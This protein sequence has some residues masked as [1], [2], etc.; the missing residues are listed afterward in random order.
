MLRAQFLREKIQIA[1]LVLETPTVLSFIDR[2]FPSNKFDQELR[3]R[4]M[5][6]LYK[7]LRGK[8]S[9]SDLAF[10]DRMYITLGCTGSVAYLMSCSPDEFFLSISQTLR[11]DI[12]ITQ[13]RGVVH[14]TRFASFLA[15]QKSDLSYLERQETIYTGSYY[16]FE[17]GRDFDTTDP[18]VRVNIFDIG[19]VDPINCC[20]TAKWISH[21]ITTEDI[22]GYLYFYNEAIFLIIS[23]NDSTYP[24]N[25]F[26]FM[27]PMKPLRFLYGIAI[28]STDLGHISLPVSYKT[29]F[30]KIDESENRKPFVV[31]KDEKIFKRI[32]DVV[33]NDIPNDSGRYKL[34]ADPVVERI[35]GL[36]GD[37]EFKDLLRES[38]K[39]R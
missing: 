37:P 8:T 7:W 38:P 1:Q 31:T 22:P 35:L 24:P 10:F 14:E 33:R 20:L 36:M 6:R 19:R 30:V 21:N 2:L 32:F 34:Y 26:I 23:G 3:E 16:C 4:Y 5:E 27:N 29:L 13:I 11:S 18:V 9:T 39:T 15:N 25:C 28:G 12:E 17:A